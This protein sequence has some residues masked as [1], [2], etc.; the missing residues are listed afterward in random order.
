MQPVCLV[1]SKSRI[2]PI[3]LRDKSILVAES[4]PP[5]RITA[6][7]CTHMFKTHATSR[8]RLSRHRASE[9]QEEVSAKYVLTRGKQR[10][11][12]SLNQHPT[13]AHFRM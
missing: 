7:S 1:A 9:M 3:P 6:Q 2:G 10:R 8:K 13:C 12:A 5:Y 11:Q 4:P